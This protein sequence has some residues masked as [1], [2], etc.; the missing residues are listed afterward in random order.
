[1]KLFKTNQLLIALFALC[2]II[3]SCE[4]SDDPTIDTSTFIGSIETNPQSF[5]AGGGLDM[6]GIIAG[7]IAQLDTA[8]NFEYDLKIL[9][10]KTSQGGRPAV[11][12]WGNQASAESVKA[13]DVSALSGIGLGLVGFDEFT[14]VTQEMI[15]GLASDGLFDF[16]PTTDVDNSGKP[17]LT[18][19][20]Q[21]YTK[22][23][24]GDKVV[25]LEEAEQPVFLIQSREGT[26]Y[27]FQ[28][29]SREGGGKANIRW[30]RME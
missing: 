4:D 14:T 18:K 7:R 1:M 5:P 21:E 8:P 3:V 29:I 20:E 24:I 16:D 30:A 15:Q 23:V 28:H 12:L 2:L 19:L 9:A 26:F 11:F 22:L 10:Y 6:D 27:K 17:D 13:V 25:R